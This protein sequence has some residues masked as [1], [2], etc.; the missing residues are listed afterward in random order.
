[1]IKEI[2]IQSTKREEL[3]DVTSKVQ[4]LI[5]IEEGLC[6]VFC[7]HTTA[8]ITINENADPDVNKD[9]LMKLNKEIPK[10]E[11]YAHSEGNSD[12]HIKTSLIGSSETI[13][14][15]NGKLKLETWQGIKFAEFDGPRNRKVII[16]T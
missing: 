4:E 14:I 6:V 3:I 7:P 15:E 10:D 2:N 13:I 11:G 8:G 9:I 1:M 16:K 12:A 5:D